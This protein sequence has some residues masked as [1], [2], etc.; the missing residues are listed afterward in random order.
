MTK[1]LKSIFVFCLLL[2]VSLKVSAQITVSA[3]RCEYRDAPLG[4]NSPNPQLSWLL[5]SNAQ[6]VKQTAY[7]ILVAD[8]AAL[9]Q[10]NTGNIWDSKKIVSDK[11]IQVIYAG[12][13]LASAKVYY[14][15]LM[16]WDNQGKASAWSKPSKWQMGLLTAADWKGAKW[17]A[18]EKM[19]DSLRIVPAID[20]PADS[21]WNKGNDVLP[22][23]RKEVTITKEI[24]KATIFIT[25]LGQ[26]DLS[27]NGKKVGDHFLDPGWTQYDKHAQYICF[28]ITGN[29]VK[30]GNVFG[31]M[32]GNGF[33]YVPGDRYHKLKSAYGYPKMICRTLIEYKDG[34][35][36]NVISDESWKA[37]PGPVTYS[38]IYGGE[39]YNAT[40]H[41]QGW[42]KTGFND[43]QFR[44]AVLVSGPQVLEAQQQEPLKIFDEF[45]VKKI[46]QPKPGVWVYDM[47]QNASAIPFIK[48]KGKRGTIIKITPAELLDD[49]GLVLQAPVGSPVYFNYTLNGEGTESWKPQFMYYGFRYIQIEGAV[50][51][52][53]AGNSQLPTL[54][55]VKSLHTRNSA[56]DAG[57]FTCSNELFNKIFKLID[58]AIRSNTVSVFTDCPH[59]EKLGWLE[60]AHLVGSSIH[61]NYDIA[62]LSRKV[63]RDMI[64]SQTKDGLIPD[65]APEFVKFGGPF[66]DSPE[67]G[68]SSVILP[69]YVYQWYG[70]KQI[71]QES[72]D[73]MARY[74]AYLESKSKN[75]LLYF[76]L[77]DWYDIGPKDLGPSQL[78]PGGITSTAYYYYDLTLLS[79]IAGI[80][81]KPADEKKYA[82]LA[83]G[84][85]AVYNK[86]FFNPKTSQY[87]TGS[88]A[89]NAISV[90]MGLADPEHKSKIID[91]IVQDIRN[92]NNGVTAG[93]I[94]YRYLLRVLDE[95]GRS[96]VI[97]D[98]NNRSDV[99][100]YGYQLAQGATALTESW[101]GNRISS[102]NHFMLGHL[103]EWFY[104]G[105]GGIRS[106]T[107]SN[108]FR[109][110]VIRP[111]IV[112]D[113]NE[114][115]ANYMS[116]Y[117]N[118]ANEWKKEANTFYMTTTIP[119]NTTAVIYLPAKKSSNITVGGKSIKANSTLKLINIENGKAVIKAGSGK[120]SFKVV[121]E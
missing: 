24:K 27:I 65:I 92:H 79:K 104:S 69:Y 67:W 62:T 56:A 47:G 45:S 33:Y 107:G 58:W 103:M 1:N 53:E 94:G 93:D 98:M 34:T 121:D 111:E 38:S 4:I 75:H 3:L 117:G 88:Q 112:G 44:N 40:L 82:A 11:S 35:T 106:D 46:T 99:P 68:S 86:T 42:D 71:L 80:V 83:A 102:N 31:M 21:R 17:I 30:G 13:K 51:Q 81:N 39:D 66:R 14:W 78:T 110:I 109:E 55:E 2:F 22:L 9:L 52:G 84:V 8:D 89:A 61:Y 28:D 120:Y 63:I 49:Q 113:V 108:G 16:V 105:L 118:I 32:L 25:G 101:Q 12:K 43:A 70:D 54:L 20:N 29:L 36:G 97:F 87:G 26:F 60:E 119:V 15:K 95:A 85:K 18:Y 7:R 73:M 41:R 50:P 116:P 91:N 37:A 64:N 115:K 76:G 10:K 114:V 100:G 5:A 74:V 23:M 96:D 77:G 19:P 6:N 59:R 72:Y 48:V 90:Y 57:S